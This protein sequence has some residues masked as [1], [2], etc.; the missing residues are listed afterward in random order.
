MGAVLSNSAQ[1]V[2]RLTHG[3]AH[4]CSELAAGHQPI[5][6]RSPGRPL[7]AAGCCYL[8]Y[9]AVLA[10]P[11]AMDSVGSADPTT[12][13][14]T[15]NT[16]ISNLQVWAGGPANGMGCTTSA[17]PCCGRPA[18]GARPPGPPV[19]NVRVLRAAQVSSVP[20]SS[21]PTTPSSESPLSLDAGLR[22]W[23]TEALVANSTNPKVYTKLLVSNAAAGSVI[24]K[25]GRRPVWP[26][27]R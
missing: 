12:V 7:T 6:L 8:G 22:E 14:S 18:T 5:H 1:Q 11:T 21:E 19:A 2:C 13:L 26:E 17:G 16:G 3:I 10:E 24:G 9:A 20:T 23:L 4:F 15:I 25:V 27:L